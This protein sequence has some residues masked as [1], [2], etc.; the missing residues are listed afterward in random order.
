MRHIETRT[1]T[2]EGYKFIG[3]FES[4]NILLDIHNAVMYGFADCRLPEPG[5]EIDV[6]EAEAHVANI[7]RE[8]VAEKM[9]RDFCNDWTGGP[10]FST[11]PLNTK[12]YLSST[13]RD[14]WKRAGVN[15][16]TSRLPME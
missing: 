8:W 14:A 1:Y 16:K 7:E 10:P 2:D 6:N 5:K 3:M 9:K 12:L 15:P 11:M 13:L 4:W